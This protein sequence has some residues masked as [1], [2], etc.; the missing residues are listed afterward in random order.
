MQAF[1]RF[2]WKRFWSDIKNKVAALILLGLSLYMVL[3]VE[4]KY[5]PI[6]SFD[7]EPIASTLQD[8]DYFLETKD[9]EMYGRSFMSF[10]TLKELA[11]DLLTALEAEDY[12]EA[13]VLEREYSGAMNA[14]Y[15]GQNPK[16][17]IYGMNPIERMQLQVYDGM[18]YGQ[19]SDYLLESDL[20]LTQPI[21]EG[22]TVGQSLARSWLGVMPV[23]ILVL[24]LIF[25]I[26]FFASDAQHETIARAYPFSA[27]KKSWGRTLVVWLA[28]TLTLLVGEI[29]FVLALSLFRDWGGIDL[30]VA[31]I[32]N[33][34][35][36]FSFLLQAH[37]LL[38]LV[39]LIL[40][41]IG[42][43]TG[44]LLKNS[45]VMVLLIPS[46]LILYLLDIG[47]NAYFVRQF[48]WLPL[49][50]FQVGNIVSGFQNFWHS[51][52]AFTFGSEVVSLM[53]GW[54]FVECIIYFTL[55]QQS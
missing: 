28:S 43:W 24:G 29:L 2:E 6:R 54:L 45:A 14:R 15:E 37:G 35:T 23:I 39:L 3:G 8:A 55:K 31:G 42:S 38:L 50:F 19:Y 34:L 10:G 25:G 9:S 7:S 16:Y 1:M 53:I 40:L 5:E 32:L 33:E 46:L 27:Y 30:L 11:E 4:L 36:V 48:N 12:R 49:S 51:S 41:R 44:Q 17:Y 18:S 22:K 20:Y 21:L 47:R 52:T 26:D 13:I